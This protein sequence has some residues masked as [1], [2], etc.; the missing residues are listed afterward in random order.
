MALASGER[1][2]QKQAGEN[3]P[4]PSDVVSAPIGPLERYSA[5]ADRAGTSWHCAAG[6]PNDTNRKAAAFFPARNCDLWKRGSIAD[7]C[8][9]SVGKSDIDWF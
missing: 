6:L 1:T 2:A 4:H 9:A 7:I 5:N 8:G 3:R